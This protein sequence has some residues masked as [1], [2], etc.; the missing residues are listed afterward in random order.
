MLGL[1]PGD[2]LDILYDTVNLGFL[3]IDIRKLK[4]KVI[5]WL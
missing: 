3:G 1:S 5:N 4:E 2:E